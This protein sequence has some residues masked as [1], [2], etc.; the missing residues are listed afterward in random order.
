MVPSSVPIKKL[1]GSANGN[2][3]H[4]GDKSSNFDGGGVTSSSDSCGWVSMSA[5]QP[6]TTPSVEQEMML[7]AFC[8]PT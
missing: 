5:V 1:V 6:Q 7:F 4:V 3:M 8:V 2:A